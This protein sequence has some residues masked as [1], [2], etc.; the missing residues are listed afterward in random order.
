MKEYSGDISRSTISVRSIY[1]IIHKYLN[2]HFL[3]QVPKLL[4]PQHKE[5]LMTLAGD[6]IIMAD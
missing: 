2:I 6:L 3:C 5:K 1:I 4:T